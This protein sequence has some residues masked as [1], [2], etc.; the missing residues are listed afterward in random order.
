MEA[1]F[2]LFTRVR[3]RPPPETD[4]RLTGR[5]VLD[6]AILLLKGKKVGMLQ[7]YHHMGAIWTMYAAYVTQAMPV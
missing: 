3:W 2:T 7:S 5:E 6:T 1:T 4:S